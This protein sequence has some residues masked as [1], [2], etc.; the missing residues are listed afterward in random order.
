MEAKIYT[1]IYC[2][3]GD[4]GKLKWY[5]CACD[6]FVRDGTLIKASPRYC[7]RTVGL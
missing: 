6:L 3:G 7:W 4:L 5:G 2:F 1:L